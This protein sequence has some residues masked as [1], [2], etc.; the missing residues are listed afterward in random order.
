MNPVFLELGP[1]EIRYYGLMYL[2]AFL[3]G[4]FLGKKQCEKYGISKVQIEDYAY[5]AMLSGVLGGR[6]YYVLLN[7]DYYFRYPLEILAVWNGGMAIHG[8]ILGGIIGTIIYT[9]IKK[10]NIWKIAD[11]AAAPFI[12]GQA[13][14]RIG[15]FTN[16]DAHGVPTVTPINVMLNNKFLTWWNEYKNGLH[17]DAKE[18]VPW[19]LEFPLGSP[20]G[21][22][23]PNTSVHPTMLYEMILNFIAFLSIWFF[24]RKKNLPTGY[25]FMI[26][27][28][29]YAVIRSI[30][31]IFRA[32]DLMLLGMRAPHLASLVMIVGAIFF[33]YKLRDN[34][35]SN[36]WVNK[37]KN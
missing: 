29:E 26:Y 11:I 30:V 2:T 31:T 17:T 6:L 12:M 1:L 10:I 22:Q 15:N 14:G 4:I 18:L 25:L 9:K 8:G 19:G 37:E 33:M 21:N 27:L 13:I 24:F 16:G 32:D 23:F 35:K 20:A 7:A 28:I 3:V 5:I 34:T 36:E